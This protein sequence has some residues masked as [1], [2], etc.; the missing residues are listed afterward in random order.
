MKFLRSSTAILPCLLFLAIELGCGGQY[1]PVANP[2][3]SHGGQPQNT[4]FAWVLNNNP[5]GAGSSTKIDVSGDTNLQVLSF[6]A[7]S[8]YQAFQGGVAG[9]L[10]IANQY[11]NAGH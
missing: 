3:L 6:G 1:R 9:A 4:H 2:I 8:V 11:T 10:F 5:V 7:G